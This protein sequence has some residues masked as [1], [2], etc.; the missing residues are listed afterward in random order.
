MR[1]SGVEEVTRLRGG[2]PTAKSWHKS[3]RRPFLLSR[4][5]FPSFLLGNTTRRG[6]CVLNA[7]AHSWYRFTE[8]PTRAKPISTRSESSNRGCEGALKFQRAYLISVPSHCVGSGR[9]RKSC[10]HKTSRNNYFFPSIE[11]QLIAC[12]HWSMIPRGLQI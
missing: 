5:L 10:A 3:C 6:R 12:R 11:W 2:D 9:T 7:A 4:S 8:P 1:P